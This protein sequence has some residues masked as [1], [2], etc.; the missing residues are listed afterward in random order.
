M[1]RLLASSLNALNGLIALLIVFGGAFAGLYGTDGSS[2][3]LILG[4]VGGFLVAVLACGV[5]AYL[6]LIERHLAK[7]ADGSGPEQSRNQVRSDP[8]ITN[9][10]NDYK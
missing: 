3:G 8:V 1:N 5:I 9:D 4:A 6:A 2:M 7:I 10:W